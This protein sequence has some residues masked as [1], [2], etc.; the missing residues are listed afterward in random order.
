MP[1]YCKKTDLEPDEIMKLADDFFGQGAKPE[2]MDKERKEI[3]LKKLVKKIEDCM[4][5][6]ENLNEPL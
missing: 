4:L 1:D 3:N 5:V 2:E 6:L